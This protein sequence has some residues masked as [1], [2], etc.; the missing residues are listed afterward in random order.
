MD[1]A[2]ELRFNDG[3]VSVNDGL[4][5]QDDLRIIEGLDESQAVEVLAV[6]SPWFLGRQLYDSFGRFDEENLDLSFID[7]QT[8]CRPDPAEP[9]LEDPQARESHTLPSC[10][11]SSRG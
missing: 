9:S 2:R 11:T 5:S 4:H 10:R 8:T 7:R 3:D 6:E 1:L